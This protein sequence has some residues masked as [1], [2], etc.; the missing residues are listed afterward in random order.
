[1]NMMVQFIP[2]KKYYKM[3]KLLLL[4]ALLIF[5]CSSDDGSD[6]DDNANNPNAQRL[7]ESVLVISANDGATFN[8][9][10]S[11][12]ENNRLS[13]MQC[14]FNDYNEFGQ[15][16]DEGIIEVYN[17]EYSDNAIEFIGND[18]VIYSFLL[19]NDGTIDANYITFLNGYL[20]TIE[21]GDGQ[22]DNCL[23]QCTWVNNYLT[24]IVETC[25]PNLSGSRIEEFEYT[26]HINP[27]GYYGWTLT[28]SGAA[29][30]PYLVGAMGKPSEL[31]PNKIRDCWGNTYSPI[32]QNNC[33]YF[34]ETEI[35]YEFDSQGYPIVINENS[36]WQSVNSERF[37]STSYAITYTN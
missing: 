12:D 13:T 28:G 11:Y 24:Q 37:S 15:I 32:N 14:Q 9:W 34:S 36:Y 10:F 6:S 26:N 22:D 23:K 20:N 21:S 5:A 30:M 2:I 29:A 33:N 25:S 31:L 18:E 1:M 4:S 27:I 35:T 16:F 17:I 8:Y 19:N 3:K 7:V